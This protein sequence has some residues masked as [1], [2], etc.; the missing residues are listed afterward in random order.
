MLKTINIEFKVDGNTVS[1]QKY[2]YC[3]KCGCKF[4]WSNGEYMFLYSLGHHSKTCPRC[5]QEAGDVLKRNNAFTVGY[6]GGYIHAIP[7]NTS[8]EDKSILYQLGFRDDNSTIGVPKDH[9][10]MCPPT[11]DSYTFLSGTVAGSGD[12]IDYPIIVGSGKLS[13]LLGD[14]KGGDIIW[15][16]TYCPTEADPL[17]DD[18]GDPVIL[19]PAD[20]GT[21]GTGI[22]PDMVHFYNYMHIQGS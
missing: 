10:A 6:T 11:D 15:G 4:D 19:G 9:H 2:I 16:P 22:H 8:H 12:Q 7:N 17:Y 18:E 3:W 20:D 13:D 1:Q 5:F 14:W 21:V